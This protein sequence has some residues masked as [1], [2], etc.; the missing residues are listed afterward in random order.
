MDPPSLA[1]PLF[2]SKEWIWYSNK[3]VWEQLSKA[4]LSMCNSLYTSSFPDYWS[5]WNDIFMLLNPVG[6]LRQARRLFYW[7]VLTNVLSANCNT[8]WALS[9]TVAI[10]QHL[11]H[12][13]SVLLNFHYSSICSISF[14]IMNFRSVFKLFDDSVFSQLF[15]I[16]L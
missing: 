15:I 4:Q 10:P 12:Q 1:T 16:L 8:H 7:I 9:W 3:S 13:A 11:F 6:C 14:R 5:S 2:M